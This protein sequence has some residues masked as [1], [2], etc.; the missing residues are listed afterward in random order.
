MITDRDV[1]ET[2]QRRMLRAAESLDLARVN[3]VSRDAIDL[4]RLAGKIEG[5]L[6]ALSYLDEEVRIKANPAPKGNRTE[7]G[8]LHARLT[9]VEIRELKHNWR[10]GRW[11]NEQTVAGLRHYLGRTLATIEEM[12]KVIADMAIDSYI[13]ERE[14]TG[15]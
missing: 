14:I 9:P 7:R 2:T 1:I 10:N 4:A 15:A 5:V 8:D 3:S 11:L 13:S 12:Q 6:L